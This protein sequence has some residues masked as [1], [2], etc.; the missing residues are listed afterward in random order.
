MTDKCAPGK[1]FN[2]GTCFTL[3]DLV[4]IAKSYNDLH[5]ND[6]ITIKNDKKY[7]LKKLTQKMDNNYNCNEDQVCWINT[8]VVKN[9]DN[10]E[11]SKFTFRPNGP[12]KQYEWLSTS[13]IN[14]VMIQYEKKY[15]DFK[16]FGA[17]PYDFEELP[18]LE[19]YNLDMDS[20][21]NNKKYKFGLVIN[22]DEH[23]KSGSHWVGL[24]T[25]LKKD[26]IFFFDSFAKKPGRRIRQFTTKVL[27]YMY[28]KKFNEN[29]TTDQ[30]LDLAQK[31]HKKI[32]M[33][34]VKY[35][36]V[37]H[38]FKN[39]ECGVYSMNFIIRLLNGETFE[40]I[41]ENITKD[42]EMNSCRNVYFRN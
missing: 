22:L 36:K 24:Y 30:F 27:T 10:P 42:A 3:D 8:K 6:K 19:V 25:D 23:D 37:Q 41:T 31:N 33:F 28:N 39:S 7:L 34:D 16:F 4:L 13:D 40:G 29:L 26:Q 1:K 38:Q 17:V 21:I 18:G 32:D 12:K 20:L 2:N 15:N 35:N 5:S 14:N 11:L 9:I